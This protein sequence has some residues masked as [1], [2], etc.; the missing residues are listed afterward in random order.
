MNVHMCLLEIQENPVT[1]EGTK[2]TP[3]AWEVCCLEEV[4]GSVHDGDQRTRAAGLLGARLNAREADNDR[5][6][7]QVSGRARPH[8]R[9]LSDVRRPQENQSLDS[10]RRYARARR[11]PPLFAGGAARV[12]RPHAL[13]DMRM[14]PRGMSTIRA[15]GAFV[16]PAVLNQVRRFNMH[17]TGALNK[18]GAPGRR[19]WAREES[20]TAAAHKS[21][22]P[23]APRKYP[24]STRSP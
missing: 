8:R 1:L 3:A 21:A 17:P 15:G 14:L 16:G 2:T 22:K 19:S 11:R 23:F 6:H 18:G 20:P 4:C 10:D 5:A 12:V 13:H 24:S 7:D 9:S